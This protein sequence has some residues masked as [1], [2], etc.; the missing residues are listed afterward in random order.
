MRRFEDS[1]VVS[2]EELQDLLRMDHEPKRAPVARPVPMAIAVPAG[3]SV[4]LASAAQIEAQR[5]ARWSETPVMANAMVKASHWRR[6]RHAILAAAGGITMGLLL[7][8]ALSGPDVPPEVGAQLDT[9]ASAITDLEGDVAAAREDAVTAR[10][11]AL[12][13]AVERDELRDAVTSLETAATAKPAKKKK[14]TRRR[15]SA[16][17]DERRAV[18]RR[19][20]KKRRRPRKLTRAD[21]KLDALLDGL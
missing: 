12:S 6:H 3:A 1:V 5:E 9:Q 16:R 20:A 11:E 10:A 14:R 7:A 15:S 13:L 8:F 18:A 17:R 19:P 2:I 4:V 21:K